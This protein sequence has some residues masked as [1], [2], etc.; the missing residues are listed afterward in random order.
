MFR[1]VVFA[2]IVTMI[3]CDRVNDGDSNIGL[4]PRSVLL[5]NPDRFCVTMN[6]VG[7]KIAYFARKGSEIELCVE[8]LSGNLLR[9]FLVKY[10]REARNYCWATTGN[11][12]LIEQDNDGDENT[13][14]VCLDIKTGASKD[15]MPFKNTHSHV[16]GVR[17]KVRRKFS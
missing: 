10:G 14:V 13:N 9:K 17:K 1:K 15:L 5:A 3:G 8:D 4:I 11:H 2:L 7:D 16:G 12:I 6:Y